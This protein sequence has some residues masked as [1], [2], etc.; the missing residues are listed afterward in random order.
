[1]TRV[2]PIYYKGGDNCSLNNYIPVSVLPLFSKILECLVYNKLLSF[3]N[4]Q[5]IL[6]IHRLAFRE[7][8]GTEM[9]LYY[10][11]VSN[12]EFVL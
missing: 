2:V 3:A 4:K 11:V 5:N 12:G 1:M 9:A 10:F 7:G 8:H 6:Y